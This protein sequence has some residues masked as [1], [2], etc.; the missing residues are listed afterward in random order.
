MG[1]DKSTAAADV[2]DGCCHRHTV[3]VL[4]LGLSFFF[5]SFAFNTQG[6]VEETVLYTASKNNSISAH[7]GYIRLA[8]SSATY[9]CSS[10]FSL[11]IIY[12]VMTV[13]SL[14]SIPIIGCLKAKWSMVGGAFL[15][16]FFFVGFF[17]LNA[18]FLYLSSVLV[19][20]GSAVLWNA[21]GKYI[22]LNS[23]EENS[24]KHSALFYASN[25]SSLTIGGIFLFLIFYFSDPSKEEKD[26]PSTIDQDTIYMLYGVF[27][28]ASLIGIVILT[29]LPMPTR[30]RVATES[31]SESELSL[32]SITVST[33]K[34]ILHP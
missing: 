17:L 31:P 5:T 6:F 4:L 7:A 30:T 16:G 28:S 3:N 20:F 32:M 29:V 2:N 26:D 14:I 21:Q 24:G 15:S 19:G 34:L 8:L 25:Q 10:C 22:A 9:A 23:T 12:G 13:S 27:T 11:A 18:P 1:T 33:C